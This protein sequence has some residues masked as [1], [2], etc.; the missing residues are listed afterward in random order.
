MAACVGGILQCGSSM[1]RNTG[2]D[3]DRSRI[4]AIEDRRSGTPRLRD[5]SD[6]LFSSDS[7]LQLQEHRIQTLSQQVVDTRAE[8]EKTRLDL[9]HW[10]ADLDEFNRGEHPIQLQRGD[11]DHDKIV[12]ITGEE[13]NANVER[14]QA[15]MQT[16]R[17]QDAELSQQLAI[18]QGRWSDFNARLDALDASLPTVR[19]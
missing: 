14:R 1:L 18:E 6:E 13:I 2:L 5:M 19:R 9:V 17:A 11:P 3:D 15:H 4:P 8:L 12:K 10:E 16:L 7:R